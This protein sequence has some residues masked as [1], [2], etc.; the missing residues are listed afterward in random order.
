MARAWTCRALLLLVRDLDD[1]DAV[2]A[3]QA[4][5][6]DQADLGVDVE[7]APPMPMR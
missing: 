2:L 5:Q 3:D 4:H 7:L 1:Q 6:R